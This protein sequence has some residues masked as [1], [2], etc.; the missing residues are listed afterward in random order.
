VCNKILEAMA[1]QKPV[2]LP[3]SCDIPVL[4]GHQRSAGITDD[5]IKNVVVQR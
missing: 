4:Q 5:P 1:M 3:L 2:L